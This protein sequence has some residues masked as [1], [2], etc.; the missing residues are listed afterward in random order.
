MP[1]RPIIQALVLA[2]RIYT[3]KSEKKIIAGTFNRI[4]IS[5]RVV[6]THKLEDGSQRL[7]MPGGT[8]PG[9]PS[10]YLSLTDV[11]NNTDIS[12]QIVNVSKNRVLFGTALT[13]ECHDWL[14]TIEIIIPLPPFRTFLNEPGTFSFDVVWKG[15]ILGSHRVIVTEEQP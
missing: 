13:I 8:D 15:E 14:A 4:V 1:M 11:V 9:C 3:D 7:V 12:L 6:E 5:K 10:A 2:E